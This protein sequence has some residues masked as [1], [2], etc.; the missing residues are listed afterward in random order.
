MLTTMHDVSKKNPHHDHTAPNT[1]SESSSVQGKTSYPL[2]NYISDE[3]FSPAHKAFLAPITSGVEPK[4]YKEAVQHEIWGN[5][6]K[7]DIVAFEVNKT[8]SIVVLLPGKGI[9]NIWVYK[10]KYNTDGTVE[11]HKSRLVVLG[12]MQVKRKDFKETF[13]P[14]AK[15]TTVR[16]LLQVIAGTRWIMHQMDVHNA[17]LHSDPTE[18]I[19]M[20]HPQGFQHADPNKVCILHKAIMG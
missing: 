11:R 10:I 18:K 13:A 20:K 3:R 19:Y 6:M 17:F 2:V 1:Q 9:G 16:S 7:D 8:F 15:M 14:V 4:S 5:S 12:N